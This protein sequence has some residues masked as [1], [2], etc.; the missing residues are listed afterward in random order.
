MRKLTALIAG[1]LVTP[2]IA[3]TAEASPEPTWRSCP[4]A[5]P[6]E[7][8]TVTVPVDYSRPNGPTIDVAVSRKKASG[9]RRGVLLLNPGGP[10][11][12][13]LDMPLEVGGP[14]AGSYDLIGFDPRGTGH[15]APLDC[16]LTDEQRDPV[17]IFGMPAPNGDIAESV[18]YS[19]QVAKQCFERHGRVMPHITTANTARDMDRIR[20]A[21]GEKKISYFGV[22]Y[23]TY[24]GAVYTALFPQNTDR[25][26]LDS[27]VDPKGIW[28]KMFNSWGPGAEES[29][30]DFAGWAARRDTTYGLGDTSNEVR[31]TY[32]AL[33]Q[34]LDAK[35]A[36]HYDGRSLRSHARSV[37]YQESSYP[38][39]AGL[40]QSI[41]QGTFTPPPPLRFDAS[42]ASTWWGVVCNDARWPRNVAQYQWDVL[43]ARQKYPVTNGM[44]ANIWPCA[45]WPTPVEPT[46]RISDH[47]PNVL[48]VQNLRDPA[49]PLG[50]ARSMRSVMG[51]RS[52][53]IT[54]DNAGHGVL[55]TTNNPC[56]LEPVMGYL[57]DGVMPQRDIACG[58]SLQDAQGLAQRPHSGHVGQ[59]PQGTTQQ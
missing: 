51:D 20:I 38:E 34:R 40:L 35:P 12:A 47:G 9:Q 21:L 15:S 28:Q 25:V 57:L 22:S 6:L 46:V 45:F 33:A 19:R 1:V 7:C 11:N 5:L 16:G 4:D 53:L 54:A 52:R 50:G 37:L 56:V 29:F 55:R 58:T 10:G 32:L 3:T 27:V 44:S 24:L 59:Q 26:V 39:L 49:T 41:K 14:L 48:L 43:V 13:G 36:L 23:G 17:R 2:L 31:G 18:A 8:T 30:T 42:F